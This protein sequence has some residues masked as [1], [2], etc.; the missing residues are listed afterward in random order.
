M[1][2]ILCLFAGEIGQKNEEAVMQYDDE[3]TIIHLLSDLY[4]QHITVGKIM[5]LYEEFGI[6]NNGE[7]EVWLMSDMPVLLENARMLCGG[8][9]DRYIKSPEVTSMREINIE[10]YD[11]KQ[12]C[13]TSD[14]KLYYKLLLELQLARNFTKREEYYQSEKYLMKMHEDLIKVLDDSKVLYKQLSQEMRG[15]FETFVLEY[16]DADQTMIFKILCLS[17][18]LQMSWNPIYVQMIYEET[19]KDSYT[20]DHKLYLCNQIKRLTLIHPQM[21]GGSYISKLYEEIV[22]YWMNEFSDILKPISCDERN[23]KKVVVLTLQFLGT[24]HSPTKTANERIY[25][26]GRLLDHEV[27]CINTREQYTAK[28]F[29]P[30]YD[31]CIRSIVDNYNGGCRMKHKDYL[32]DFFQ[33][34]VEMPEWKMM[35]ALLMVIREMAP[36]KVIVLGDRCLLGDLCA[37]IIP[38]V[39][40]PMAFSTIPKKDNQYVAVGKQLTDAE[41]LDLAETG[42]RMSSI[43]ESTFTFEL[44]EQTVKLTR[45]ELGLPVNKFLLVVVGIRLD[46]EVTDEFLKMLEMV[47]PYN[48]HVVFAGEFERYEELCEQD[49]ALRQHSTFVGYQ[50]DI[51]ALMENCDLYVN[52]PRVGGGFSVVEAFYKGVPGVTTN[53]GDVAAS[54][55][56]DFCVD[57]LEQ[58]KDRIIKYHEDREY[59]RVMSDK[60]LQ[61]SRELFDSKGAMK[62]ILDE[63]EKRDLW[64]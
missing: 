39:C 9:F 64:F 30:F 53:Y 43:I 13:N 47:Y 31:A 12:N 10:T 17:F 40:I 21:N 26:I 46:A 44:V 33:P 24:H 51:L 1:R 15:I 42:Y 3:S 62:H 48:M 29:L 57:S 4:A 16:A 37:E 54:A 11:H 7:S 61:R 28:G 49:E 41:R 25:T 45:E 8:L 58:M 6:G 59:Y 20:I 36:W 52:P 32:Y 60:A 27:L 5:F 50:K 56:L 55:G 18:L 63:M 19:R 23:Q 14:W 35:R 38:T 22:F 2:T 34:E